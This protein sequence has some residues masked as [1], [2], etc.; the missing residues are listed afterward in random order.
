M[1]KQVAY[2]VTT[3]LGRLKR[4]EGKECMVRSKTWTGNEYGW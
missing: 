3:A 4:E 2:V 1:V